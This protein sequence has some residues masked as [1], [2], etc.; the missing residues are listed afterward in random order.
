MYHERF[1]RRATIEQARVGCAIGSC[2]AARPVCSSFGGSGIAC[3]SA[4]G[5]TPMTRSTRPSPLASRRSAH[6]RSDRPPPASD[7]PSC[8]NAAARTRRPRVALSVRRPSGGN[9]CHRLER[10]RLSRRR[11]C[12]TPT[13]RPASGIAASSTALT[14]RSV[15]IVGSRAASAVALETAARTRRRSRAPRRDRRQRPGARR[16]L[17]CHRGA[18]RSGATDRGARVRRGSHLS[19]RACRPRDGHRRGRYS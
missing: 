9:Q 5:E 8:W 1:P 7:I 14:R 6:D 18:L 11:C 17:R 3:A 10:R 16:R 12:A 2:R 13:V 4:H 15:A 19:G